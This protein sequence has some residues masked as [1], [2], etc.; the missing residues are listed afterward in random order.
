M[1]ITKAAQAARLL[2][3]VMGAAAVGRVDES[4]VAAGAVDEGAGGGAVGSSS[5]DEDDAG[6]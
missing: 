4:D 6:D 1:K 3:E 2:L 5:C